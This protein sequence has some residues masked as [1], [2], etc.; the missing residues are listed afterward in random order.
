[1]R[2]IP[3]LEL[4][5][6]LAD[7]FHHL[8]LEGSPSAGR[9]VDEVLDC[10]FESGAVPYAQLH[11]PFENR[12]ALDAAF[13]YDFI[14]EGLDQ[15]RGWFYTLTV[16]GT[17]LFGRCPF[18]NLICNGLVLAADGKKMSKRLQNYPEPGRVLAQHGADAL[19]LYLVNSPAVRAEPL[20]FRE[21]GVRDCVRDVL[22]PWWNAQ[23][24]LAAQLDALGVAAY[25][26]D[27]AAASTNVTDRWILAAL[28]TLVATVEAE[29]AAYRL[30]AVLP[31]CLRFLE[32][33]TNWFIRLNRRR[34]K[35][36]LPEQPAGDAVTAC[37][38]L[39]HVLHAFTL[40]MAP[41]AP[42]LAEGVYQRLRPRLL[43][44]LA[45]LHADCR[46]VH[47]LALP[48]VDAAL[49]DAPIERAMAALQAVVEQVRALRKLRDLPLKTP[50][51]AVTVV[52]A[53]DEQ[54]LLDLQG[55]QGYLLEEAN[56]R[57]LCVDRDEAA[58]GVTLR[59]APNFR[60]LGQRLKHDLVPVQRALQGLDAAQLAA[61]VRDG[62]IELCGHRLTAEDLQ[63]SRALPDAH[64]QRLAAQNILALCDSHH[65]VLLDCS[66]DAALRAEGLA[67]E[68]VNRAQRLRK[69]AGLK[70]ADA[71]RVVVRVC[72]DGAG[73]DGACVDGA[74]VDSACAPS[75]STTT[76]TAASNDIPDALASQR[77]FI[78]AALHQPSD[79]LHLPGE[80]AGPLD[81]AAVIAEDDADI[82]ACLLKLSLVRL[83]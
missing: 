17:H 16:L 5:G 81:P 71:V 31:A 13:P 68:L 78:E 28:Q 79:A 35:A 39:L 43:P 2:Q 20:R 6:Q 15:T 64:V 7:A 34:L 10:W 75:A 26:P 41:F 1:M 40:V 52:C 72:A 38:V 65:L 37:Q 25:A 48:R 57:T 73:V 58:H 47:F 74:C 66:V 22:L 50:L 51:R 23:R 67:R 60:L 4:H 56:V 44:H 24:F 62:A 32:A 59:A 12:A 8:V 36:E 80:D 18:R 55:L 83:E 30:Y 33:L 53:A 29:M 77:A 61:L 46:S 21:D 11:Y 63:V 9:R 42:L 49:R 76:S 14:A 54:F 19:R 69:R 27:V 45:A 70:S 3:D 82:S